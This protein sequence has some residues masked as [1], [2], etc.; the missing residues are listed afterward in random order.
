[1]NYLPGRYVSCSGES[2]P[3]PI[4]LASSF[5]DSWKKEKKQANGKLIGSEINVERGCS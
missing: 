2:L 1:V 3:A 5:A 4:R